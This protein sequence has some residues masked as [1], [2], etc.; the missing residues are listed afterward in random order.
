MAFG[1][2]RLQRGGEVSRACQQSQPGGAR[3][4]GAAAGYGKRKAM[5]FH[6]IGLELCGKRAPG[7][8]FG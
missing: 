7:A 5:L 4:K 8:P 6:G 2:A 3:L 1:F